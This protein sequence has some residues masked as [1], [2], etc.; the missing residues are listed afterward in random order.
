MTASAP[1]SA[2]Q[3]NQK[4]V[5]LGFVSVGIVG[6]GVGLVLWSF[7]NPVAAIVTALGILLFAAAESELSRLLS[8][9]WR[10][11]HG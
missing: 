6:Q 1:E 7:R 9:D 8:K 10:E 11:R 3:P 5:G 4:P 2:K